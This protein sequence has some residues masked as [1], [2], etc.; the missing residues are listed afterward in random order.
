V[1]WSVHNEV[2]HARDVPAHLDA[3]DHLPSHPF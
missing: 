2:A 3:L 1:R